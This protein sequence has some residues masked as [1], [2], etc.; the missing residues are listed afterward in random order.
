LLVMDT[1]NKGTRGH[2]CKLK[3][4]VRYT[5]DIVKHFFPKR[6]INRWNELD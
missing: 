6:V 2:S 5:R 4:K 3:K 1:N